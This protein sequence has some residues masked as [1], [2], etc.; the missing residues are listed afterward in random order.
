MNKN[1]INKPPSTADKV[2][3]DASMNTQQMSFLNYS[4]ARRPSQDRGPTLKSK[5]INRASMP[6]RGR[7]DSRNTFQMLNELSDYERSNSRGRLSG[8][9]SGPRDEDD[10]D[11]NFMKSQNINAVKLRD[12]YREFGDAIN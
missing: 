10:P 3:P 1:L 8:L 5:P 12:L 9:G 2:F 7:D 4:G 11:T 6:K